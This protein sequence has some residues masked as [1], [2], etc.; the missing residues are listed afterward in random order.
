[1][2]FRKGNKRYRNAYIGLWSVLAC[3]L[4]LFLAWSLTD[5]EITILGWSPKKAP[6]AQ[7]LFGHN[8]EEDSIAIK[9]AMERAEAEKNIIKTDSTSQ[10]IFIFGDSMTMHLAERLAAYGKQNGHTV[11][12]VNW[13]SS[14]T[15]TWAGC[16]TIQYFINKFKPTMVF[17]ALGANEVYLKKPE[18]RLPEIRKIIDKIG[19]VPFVWIGPPSLKEDG[20]LNDLLEKTLGKRN[21]FRSC[22]LEMERKRDHVHPTRAASALWI[23]SVMRWLPN[24]CHPFIATTPSDTIGKATPNIVFLK[25][26]NR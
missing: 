23:D 16:D 24:S 5:N 20:G 3:A 25:A 22:G 13:D 19:D 8:E 21:F 4:I 7:T 11:N 6:F 1:M 26:K 17:I 9:E 2:K 12:A 10:S 15:K 14:N 18:I